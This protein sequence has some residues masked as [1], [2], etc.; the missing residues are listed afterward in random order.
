MGRIEDKNRARQARKRRIRGKLRG[1]AQQPRLAIFRSARHIYAQIIDDDLGHVL[2]SAS[3]LEKELR[4]SL[5]TG[6]NEDAAKEVGKL[7]AERAVRQNIEMVAFDRGGF[8]FH[9]RLKA[10]AEAAR[11][12]GLKF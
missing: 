12:G 4:G 2:A 10:L 11:E 9:G 5:K 6:G 1:T 7:I 3:T 8:K